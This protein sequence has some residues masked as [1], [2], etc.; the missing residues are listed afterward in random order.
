MGLLNALVREQRS[1]VYNPL[2]PGDPALVRIFGDAGRSSSGINVT[3]DVALS[4]SAVFAGVRFIAENVASVPLKLSKYAGRGKEPQRD[5]PRWTLLQHSANDEQTAMEARE[6][7]AGHVVLC[8]NGYQEI[9]EGPDGIASALWPI[10]P[11]RVRLA[12]NPKTGKLV[13]AVKSPIDGT[14]TPIPPER[15]LHFRGFSRD[16]LMG[17]DVIWQMRDSLGI[18]IAADRAAGKFFSN[19]SQPSGILQT[20]QKLSDQAWARLEKT[21]DRIDS[22]VDNFHRLALL[23]E[24]LKWQQITTDPE[25][26]QLL[27]SR[28]FGV[29]EVARILNLPVH[30]LKELDR[31]TNNNIEHQGI[32]LVR[33]TFRPLC[34]RFE[35]VYNKR[36]LLPT[37][38][39]THT[40]QYNL[41]GFLRG[42]SASRFEVY[43]KGRQWGIY[44]AN[45]VREKE[46]EN[47]IGPQGDIYMAP[48]N[49]V[50]ADRLGELLDQPA[51]PPPD[52]DEDDPPDARFAYLLAM[53]KRTWLPVFQQR[54][55][56]LL[57]RETNTVRGFVKKAA[58]ARELSAL[59]SA[60]YEENAG[61]VTGEVRPMVDGCAR[62]LYDFACQCFGADASRDLDKW[63]HAFA[64]TI[65]EQESDASAGQL[66]QLTRDAADVTTM[67][68]AITDRL[69]VWES[70]RAAE[71]AARTLARLGDAITELA[72]GTDV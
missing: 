50:P 34:V 55:Q 59:T 8:G 70:S 56:S 51:E 6:T 29:T 57:R 41:E 27:E 38:R 17:L 47:G 42:D 31:S 32:E 14:E 37:E 61:F 45:D 52:D 44:S 22:G 12:R 67:R 46:D 40:I 9:V 19:G 25:K 53:T 10:P 54:F 16:G 68:A 11:W 66:R 2:H 49:M 58:D 36:L 39:G 26:S 5:D 62:Q 1:L 71:Q 64:H 21:R 30:I 3:E 24:G 48:V 33:Y 18:V 69:S 13:Y 7:T 63:T 28:K 35:Q 43:A 65:G 72:H 23:E 60:F 15:M 4:T 20:D